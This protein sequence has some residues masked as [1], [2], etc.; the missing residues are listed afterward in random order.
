MASE[1]RLFCKYLRSKLQ[2]MLF[3]Y[4]VQRNNK[5]Y[6]S[7]ATWGNHLKPKQIEVP[8]KQTYVRKTNINT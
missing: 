1:D 4:T 7:L 8:Y 2:N 5:T 6:M 3:L